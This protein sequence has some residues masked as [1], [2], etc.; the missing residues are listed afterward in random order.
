MYFVLEA[1]RTII[2]K[3]MKDFHSMDYVIIVYK[4]FVYNMYNIMKMFNN[5]R[6]NSLLAVFKM[7]THTHI[8]CIQS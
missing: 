3:C 5:K 2:I 8:N 4:F 1:K 6:F 7:Q